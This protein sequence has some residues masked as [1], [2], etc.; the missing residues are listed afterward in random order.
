MPFAVS[1]QST[2]DHG[3]VS[4]HEDVTAQKR[5]ET[6]IAY[7]LR[8]T[9]SSPTSPTARSCAR[10]LEALAP[11]RRGKAFDLFMLD[12]DIFKSG[13]RI[14]LGH[15]VGGQLLKVVARRLVACLR[16]R[17]MRSR[18]SAATNSRSWPRWRGIG[19]SA[20]TATADRLLAGGI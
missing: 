8:A 12:L 11:P 2:P 19:A 3:W 20:A 10:M 15:P 4:I 17:P 14:S 7:L 9:M 16:E 1:H 5:A 13:Q 18:G 6:Q